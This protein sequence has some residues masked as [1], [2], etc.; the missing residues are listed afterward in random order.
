MSAENVLYQ[1]GSNDLDSKEPDDVLQEAEN[2][3]EITKQILQNG[4]II[5]TEILLR[6]YRDRYLSDKYEEKRQRYNIILKGYC[7]DK[8]IEI[9]TYSK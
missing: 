3:V 6:F 1:I 2:L 8:D 5:L 7:H 4:N 9:V